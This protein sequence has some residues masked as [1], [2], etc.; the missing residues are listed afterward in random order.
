M[1]KP[2]EPEFIDKVETNDDEQPLQGRFV[3]KTPCEEHP[4]GWI[5]TEYYF[6]NG[7]LHGS[8]AIIYPDGRKE[9]WEN[10]VFVR[11]TPPPKGPPLKLESMEV[12]LNI[13]TYDP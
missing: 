2:R 8:P 9:D 6:T 4:I 5:T 7:K 12:E 3:R 1:D 10:G 11:V 13:P